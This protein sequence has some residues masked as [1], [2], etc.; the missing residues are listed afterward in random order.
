M[1]TAGPLPVPTA[2]PDADR[3]FAPLGDQAGQFA[4]I[5]DYG[6]LVAAAA[7]VLTP[8]GPVDRRRVCV[9]ADK[10]VDG[11]AEIC[12]NH[13]GGALLRTYFYDAAPHAGRLTAEH[14]MLSS[15]PRVTLR[16]GR[17]TADGRQKGVD[18]RLVLDSYKL[19]LTGRLDRLYL[20]TGD[21][22]VTEAVTE[23]QDLGVS[24]ML[25]TVAGAR[26]AT[27]ANLLRAV[28]ESHELGRDWL[29]DRLFIKPPPAPPA[30]P[31][32]ADPAA[33]SGEPTPGEADPDGTA[34]GETASDETP[35]P[36]GLPGL[37]GPDGEWVARGWR[38]G[39][40]FA[41]GAAI[42]E[43]AAANTRRPELP[44]GTLEAAFGSDGLIGVSRS[45]HQA[46]VNGFWAAYDA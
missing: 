30:D 3:C 28:D 18:T 45:A 38:A 11:L 42:S 17:L 6:F 44:D 7:E 8:E 5:V 21:D 41:E 26:A 22:D 19:A 39:R 31:A 37:D 32:K 34:S 2:G 23:V 16:L 40:S 10:L 43:W 25:L 24:V 12:R 29:A 33:E 36:P 35:V 27:S 9:N 1:S 15:T 4:V 14:H 46:F 20:L 13:A